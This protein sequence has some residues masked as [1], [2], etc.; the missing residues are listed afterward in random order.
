MSV[1]MKPSIN[2]P[3]LLV[4]ICAFLPGALALE[5]QPHVHYKQFFPKWDALLKRVI[6]EH[7]SDKLSKYLEA[8]GPLRHPSNSL[9][10]CILDVLDEPRKLE[11]AASSVILGL[12]PAVLQFFSLTTT[13]IAFLSFRRP[14]LAT[15]LAACSPCVNALKALE[16]EQAIHSMSQPIGLSPRPGFLARRQN[17][18]MWLVAAIQYLVAAAAVANVGLL[19]WQLATWSIIV[20]VEQDFLLPPI[21]VVTPLLIHLLG[22]WALRLRISVDHYDSKGRRT[23]S[24]CRRMWRTEARPAAFDKELLWF[25]EKP[26]GYCSVVVGWL[27]HMAMVVQLVFGTSILSGVIFIGF[28]DSI[29]I[30]ARLAMSSIACRLIMQYETLGM[31]S[32]YRF[33]AQGG[34]H[35]S[36][37]I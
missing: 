34:Q 13:D 7:C 6:R 30:I 4:A 19:A 32:L 27:V 5:W 2:G 25:R 37:P 20:Y 14:L 24:L 21:W 23:G 28:E 35:G 29:L 15:M 36:G 22:A 9:V 26:I 17:W 31:R 11:I 12:A 1:I 18:V 8:Q 33:R 16:Y 10:H 3:L